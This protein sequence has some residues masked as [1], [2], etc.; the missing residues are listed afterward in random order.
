MKN[1]IITGGAGFIGSRLV[2]HILTQQDVNVIVIDN[3]I[4]SGFYNIEEFVSHHNFEFIK[5]DLTE[6]ID[7]DKFDELNKFKLKIYG[8]EEIYHLACPTAPRDHQA[9]PLEVSLANSQATKN[10]LEAARRY[11][12]QF[13]FASASDV[14]G[15][16]PLEQQPVKESDVGRLEILGLHGAYANGK[17]FA[18]NLVVHY[19]LKFNFK[20]KIVRLFN[21]YGPEM[22]LGDGRIITDF[23]EQTLKN[24]N[25]IIFGDE[26]SVSSFCYI[27]DMIDGLLKMMAHE[28]SGPINLGGEHPYKLKDVAEAIIH[29]SNSKSQIVYEPLKAGVYLEPIPD[30]TLAKEKLGWLPVVPIEQGLAKTVEALEAVKVLKPGHWK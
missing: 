11:Q 23:I 26:K 14:Y 25:I 18:E 15:E 30:I 4:T 28:E 12:A 6:P 17:R 22:R 19:G 2:H 9:L 5:H 21:T 24:E 13:L 29:L 20:T 3:F 16:V 10:I 7:L 8:I 1:I 27:D